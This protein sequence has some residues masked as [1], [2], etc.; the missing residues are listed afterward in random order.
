MKTLNVA[1]VLSIG[2]KPVAIDINAESHLAAIVHETG[3]SLTIADLFNNEIST[4]PV[5]KHP[6]DVAVNPLDN[7]A[8]VL[9]DED[10]AFQ[11]KTAG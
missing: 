7:S 5:C 8:L 4:V 3:N 10:R 9:C 11:V 6:V 1:A 2:K